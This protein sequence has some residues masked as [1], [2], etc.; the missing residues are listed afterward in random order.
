MRDLDKLRLDLDLR[1][2]GAGGVFHEGIDQVEVLLGIADDETAAAGE[3]VGAG[4]GRELHALSFEEVFGAAADHGVAAGVGTGPA[5]GGEAGDEA[6]GHAVFLGDERVGRFA[7]RHDEDGVGLDLDFEVGQAGDVVEGFAQRDVGE[8]D[9]DG[10]RSGRGVQFQHDVDPAVAIRGIAVLLGGDVAQVFDGLAHGGVGEVE[11]GDEDLVEL[12]VDRLRAA[13]GQDGLLEHGGGAEIGAFDRSFPRPVDFGDHGCPRVV[14][15]GVGHAGAGEIDFLHAAARGDVVAVEAQDFLVFAEG[16]V[17][18]RGIVKTLG[19]EKQ[20]FDFLD[21]ADEARS[22][23]LVEIVGRL[24]AGEEA[25]GGLVIRVVLRLEQHLDGGLGI[26]PATFG[27]AL[28]GQ[29]HD[30]FGKTV[31]GDGAQVADI[32]CVG[33]GIDGR[34]VLRVGRFVFAA[35]QRFRAACH[36]LGRVFLGQTH[37]L[38]DFKLGLRF[39]PGNGRGTATGPGVEVGEGEAEGQREQTG[40][41]PAG[42]ASE[43]QGTGGSEGMHYWMVGSD[44]TSAAAAAAWKGTSCCSAVCR[45]SMMA[46]SSVTSTSL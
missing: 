46:F 22:D 1:G 39:D 45:F 30:R 41:P 24:E 5:A 4:S 14:V 12:A 44:G 13:A 26:F 35:H 32:G 19:V 18:P 6:R 20:L 3:E 2:D 15:S 17:E 40:P 38:G 42:R 28:L 7:D 9:G 21:L 8:V 23:R 36:G 10:L 27:D 43:R 29:S 37:A 34:L 33:Q 25:L 16:F 31:E 11:A